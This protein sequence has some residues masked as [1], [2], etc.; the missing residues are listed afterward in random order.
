[1]GRGFSGGVAFGVSGI[2]D[3]RV[4]MRA[5]LSRGAGLYEGRGFLNGRGFLSGGVAFLRVWL[6]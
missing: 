1:M 2:R 6:L 5:W 3:G 4:F